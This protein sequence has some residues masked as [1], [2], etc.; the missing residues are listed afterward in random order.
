MTHLTELTI[1]QALTKLRAKE[2]SSVELTRAYLEQIERLNPTI[3]AY[4][5]VTTEA[6]L[7]AAEAADRARAGGDERPLLGIPLAIKDVLST[8]G[9]ETTCGSKILKG[10]TPIYDATVV[11]RLYE[12]GMVMLGKTNCDE[13]AMG[14][15]TEN[16]AYAITRNPW[17]SARSATTNCARTSKAMRR[18]RWRRS[19]AS[20]PRRSATW[21]ASSPA[22]RPR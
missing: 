7:K 12:A 3:Q 2:I 4:L 21:R 14:S 17:D 16:S 10:Y 13:F 5:T 19:A 20:M 9:I 1:T 8:Q 22:P 18:R 6:A 15:S 11:K